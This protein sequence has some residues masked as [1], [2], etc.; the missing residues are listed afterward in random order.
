[1]GGTE[2]AM[3]QLLGSSLARRFRVIHVDSRVRRLN[4]ERGR[5][6]AAALARLA[7]LCVTIL[8]RA[9]ASRPRVA[10]FPVGSNTSGFLR[11]AV[12]ILVLRLAVGH[13]V[14]HYRGGH[15]SHFYRHAPRL[16]R[17]VIRLALRQADELVVLGEAIKRSFAGAYPDERQITVVH[18]GIDLGP[19]P[20]GA[21]IA[22]RR[23]APFT[24]LYVGN[25]SFVKGFF[26]LIVAYTRLR[27]RFPDV[28]LLYAG[29]VISVDEERN[30]LRAYF[31]SEVQRRMEES[32]PGIVEF[33]ADSSAHNA[34]HL[35][36]VSG[37]AKR[38]AF[39]RASVFV[40]PSYSEGFSMS[41]LEAMAAGLPVVTTD[42]GAM[43]EVVRDGIDGYL[44][45]PGDC[46]S[47][48]ERLSILASDRRLTSR[49][50]EAS[51]ARAE[52]RFDIERVAD[53][54]DAL[55]TRAIAA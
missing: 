2:H 43:S 51:R 35:G 20:D 48:C 55:F 26:D 24:I 49:M 12:V 42:V 41:V 16:M 21:T 11:D 46:E 23:Q 13:I 27:R 31:D 10:Y 29:E 6:D 45:S 5:I 32:G 40:L 25:L 53:A 19:A 8:V 47:L 4:S 7:R 33:V 50:G 28:S 3:A 1:M 34:T 44:V 14:L 54:L 15:F 52:S 39:A 30:I 36:L 9:I 37:E 38:D 22:R 18:N 17:W